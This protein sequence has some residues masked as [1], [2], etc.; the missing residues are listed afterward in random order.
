MSSVPLADSLSWY[1]SLFNQPALYPV[2]VVLV[3]SGI[4]FWVITT[5][6]RN[7]GWALGTVLWDIGAKHAA[8]TSRVVEGYLLVAKDRDL[9]KLPPGDYLWALYEAIFTVPMGILKSDA[10]S[11]GEYGVL[12]YKVWD[13]SHQY[14]CRYLPN[15]S[16]ELWAST[17]LYAR[18]TLLACIASYRRAEGMA[19][20]VCWFILLVGAI[21]IYVPLTMLRVLEVVLLGWRGVLIILMLL[22]IANWFY[23][24]G[25]WVTYSTGL[26]VV[27]IAALITVKELDIGAELDKISPSVVASQ[28]WTQVKDG[29]KSRRRHERA[30]MRN[31]T[32]EQATGS[33]RPPE[34]EA[35]EPEQDERSAAAIQAELRQSLQRVEQLEAEF[36]RNSTVRR[37]R[38]HSS[39]GECPAPGTGEHV[40][41]A[42][43]GPFQA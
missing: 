40:P 15:T 42:A 38:L 16:Q 6:L 34:G 11:F 28:G 13:A 35:A 18:G 14:W 20:G 31:L 22:N 43:Q 1:W 23:Q 8:L 41:T 30:N 3:L 39:R 7:V 9:C 2:Y 10:D 12:A 5:P 26:G 4:L 24:W 21:L 33:V 25:L 32:A 37:G 36:E 17:L 27:L 19:H 29:A